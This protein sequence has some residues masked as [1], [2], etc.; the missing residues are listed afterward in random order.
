MNEERNGQVQNDEPPTETPDILIKGDDD[1]RQEPSS[2]TQD[3]MHFAEDPHEGKQDIMMKMLKQLEL[4]KRA[5]EDKEEA[6][7]EEEE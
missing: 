7:E 1:D 5:G 2:A 4:E 6:G 3:V